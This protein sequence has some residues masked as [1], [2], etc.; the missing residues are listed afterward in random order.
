M[1]RLRY[2]GNGAI[3]VSAQSIVTLRPGSE[4]SEDEIGSG[5]FDLLIDRA[6]IEPVEVDAPA[7]VES[8][9]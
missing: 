8:E 2:I 3:S 5:V 9:D 4:A 1:R 7:T 6:D